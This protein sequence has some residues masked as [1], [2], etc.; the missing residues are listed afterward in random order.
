VNDLRI[1]QLNLPPGMIDF[2][3]GQ[4]S[5]SLLPLML[6]RKAAANRLNGNDAAFLAYGAEQGPIIFLSPP[7]HPWGWICSVPCLPDPVT[8]FLWK[9]RLI[10]WPCAFLPIII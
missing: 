3:V 6:L 4:P 1:A 2:G 5:P 8:P 10:F 7:V 9:S